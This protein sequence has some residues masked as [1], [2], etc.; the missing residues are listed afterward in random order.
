MTTTATTT[1]DRSAVLAGLARFIAQRSGI[2][3]RNYRT[4]WADKDGHAA[5]MHDYRQV[6]RDGR[7]ARRLLQAVQAREGIDVAELV[8]ASRSDRLTLA[9]DGSRWQFT[10]CQYFPTEYRMA[11]CRILAAALW[12]YWRADGLTRDEIQRQARRTLGR[13]IAARWFN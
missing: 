4:S 9:D 6:L 5:F 8:A 12:Q 13:A 1:A 2:D 7:Q 11:A 10:P 3:A